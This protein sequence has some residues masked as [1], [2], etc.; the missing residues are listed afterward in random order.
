MKFP[1]IIS[2]VLVA[3]YLLVIFA[4]SSCANTTV[5]NTW[6][7]AEYSNGPLKKVLVLT[8]LRKEINNKTLQ[9]ALV[10]QLKQNGVDAIAGYKAFDFDY[11]PTKDQI[12]QY[13]ADNQIDSIMVSRL[14]GENEQKV[15]QPTTTYY[16][17][18]VYYSHWDTYYPRM[19]DHV[20]FVAT[21][22][23]YYMETNIY[24]ASD[25]RLIWTAV[26]ETLEP[27]NIG[28]EIQAFSEKIISTIKS[29]NLI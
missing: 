9:D 25:K 3:N 27:S 11:Q 2:V 15:Y 17:P 1:N 8:G 28:K 13:A 29:S 20:G 21:Y 22:K 19:Y 16:A 4:I 10:T 7:D 6:K 5:L 23:F 26:T 18:H 12:A 24:S 14:T